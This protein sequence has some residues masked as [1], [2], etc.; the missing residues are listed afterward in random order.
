MASTSRS[1]LIVSSVSSDATTRTPVTRSP[2]IT[3]STARRP[4]RIRTPWQREHTRANRVFEQRPGDHQPRHTAIAHGQPLAA[5]DP[6][7]VAQ[8]IAGLTPLRDEF[9][10]ESGKEPLE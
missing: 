7:D 6:R 3:S 4:E 5:E 1:A 9:G 10:D 8:V 2:L